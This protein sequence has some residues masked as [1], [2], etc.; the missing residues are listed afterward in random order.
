MRNQ[1]HL[2]SNSE[3]SPEELN[4]EPWHSQEDDQRQNTNNR[5]FGK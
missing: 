2:N 1:S 5:E 3:Q 4:N